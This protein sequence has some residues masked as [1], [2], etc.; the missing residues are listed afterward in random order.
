[1]ASVS[2]R[3]SLRFFLVFFQAVSLSAC[4]SA[5]IRDVEADRLFQ[6]GNYAEAASFLKERIEKK[7]PGSPGSEDE[8]LYLLDA[9]LSLHQAGSYGE[10]NGYFALAEKHFGL[11]DY[12]SVSEEVGTLLTSE[13]T[14]VYRG[15][16]FERVLIHVFKAMNFALMGS[17]ESS[18]VEARLVNRRLEQMKRDGQRTYKQ[19]AFARYISAILYESQ[20]ELNDA[21]VDYK[22]TRELIPAF[23]P[24]GRDLWRI[25]YAL[26]M[27]DECERWK[28]EFQLSDA[29]SQPES[30]RVLGKGSGMGEVIVIYQNGISPEKRPDP[31]FPS[32]PRFVARYNPVTVAEVDLN[33]EF[34]GRTVILH[35]IEETAIKNLEEKKAGMAAK[36]VAGRVTKAVVADQIKRRTNSELLGALTEIALVVSDQADIRSWRLLP[37]DLQILRLAVP[38]GTHVIRVRPVGDSD[39]PEQTVEVKAG[40]KVFLSFRY[41][42]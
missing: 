15:E 30:N 40:K 1:M 39:L 41:S 27:S 34:A 2:K 24:V 38:E 10:S 19:N 8:L 23:S 17:I 16:D 42:P 14:K 13:N 37:R 35:D 11:N 18:L 20:G 6:E 33:G 28:K 22:K 31:I 32:L 29:D 9:G 25:A 3:F 5:R 12:T 4:V 26:R 21:Y 36:R 7:G